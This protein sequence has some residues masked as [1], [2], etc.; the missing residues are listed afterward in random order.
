MTCRGVHGA[1]TSTGAAN[2][3]GMTATAN[4]I[5]AYANA[6]VSEVATGAGAA[7][8]VSAILTGAY[9]A[10]DVTAGAE[11]TSCY[12]ALSVIKICP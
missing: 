9:S 12:W 10:D 5:P 2:G 1:G 4:G 6:V 7:G 3:T 8:A 11:G